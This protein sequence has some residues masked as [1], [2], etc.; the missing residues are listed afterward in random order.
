[1]LD[2]FGVPV[3]KYMQGAPLFGPR[4]AA[5]KPRRPLRTAP[6]PAPEKETRPAAEV[7]P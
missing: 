5:D 7:R 1:V 4:R 3:P 6:L 2:L